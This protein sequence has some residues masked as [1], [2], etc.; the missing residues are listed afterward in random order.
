[1]SRCLENRLWG[2]IHWMLNGHHNMKNRYY[3]NGVGEY[4]ISKMGSWSVEFLH[5]LPCIWSAVVSADILC[6][7]YIWSSSWTLFFSGRLLESLGF[8]FRPPVIAVAS[9]ISF[10]RA[11]DA[12]IALK[13]TSF[14]WTWNKEKE[15]GGVFGGGGG[16]LFVWKVIDLHFAYIYKS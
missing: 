3:I 5:Q 8:S 7:S 11:P 1:M 15:N 10:R 9:L 16:T 6:S 4:K 12:T 13:S 14:R 2:L